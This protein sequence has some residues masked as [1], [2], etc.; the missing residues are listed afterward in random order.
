M[1]VFSA[2]VKAISAVLLI[3]VIIL[4]GIL[5]RSLAQEQK[6]RVFATAPGMTKE[7]GRYQMLTANVIDQLTIPASGNASLP[8]RNHDRILM[9]DTV[10]GQTW[11]LDSAYG[12]VSVGTAPKSTLVRP[13]S[14]PKE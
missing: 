6:P 2:R 8:A 7:I 10:T 9:V 4:G 11:E 5:S 12:W 14:K 3:A 13:Y 1:K